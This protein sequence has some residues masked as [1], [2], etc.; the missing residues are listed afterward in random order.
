MAG[1]WW[2][3]VRGPLALL[4]LAPFFG[5]YVVGSLTLR[6]LPLIEFLVPLYGG[7]ALLV[8]EVARRTRSGWPAI[9]LLGL[10]FGVVLAG[11]TDGSLF[12]PHYE[13]MDL[14]V[15]QVPGLGIS[16]VFG[17]AF[18]VNHALVSVAV[19]VA[20][21]EALAP[22]S[23]RDIPWFGT[24]GLMVAALV[25]V[26]GSLLIA[27]DETGPRPST[28]QVGGAAVVAVALVAVALALP[29]VRP[30]VGPEQPVPPGPWFV[31]L[32]ALVGYALYSNVPATWW[33]VVLALAILG[34]GVGTGVALGRRHGWNRTTRAAAVAGI[35]LGA[36][37]MSF[38][39][40][41]FTGADD[42]STTLGR[43]IIGLLAAVILLGQLQRATA[44][45]APAPYA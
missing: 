37:A 29:P 4:V 39:V 22:P 10:C 14:T 17:P 44:R 26:G 25:W 21:A 45:R 33:G 35:G 8:R 27:S 42:P 5:E 36:A 2:S 30:R 32:V 3:R 11:I 9:L 41:A 24:T 13:G 43:A 7:G 38:Q 31:G 15:L 34:V 40:G 18:V 28:G 19:P 16:A 6:D 23:R 1:R 12:D 20:V